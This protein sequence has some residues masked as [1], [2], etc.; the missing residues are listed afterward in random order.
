MFLRIIIDAYKLFDRRWLMIIA[1]GILSVGIADI[2]S[3]VSAAL[4]HLPTVAMMGPDGKPFSFNYSVFID[5]LVFFVANVWLEGFVA[6]IALSEIGGW[7]AKFFEMAYKTT[8][9]YPRVLAANFVA[10]LIMYGSLVLAYAA[11]SLNFIGFLFVIPAFLFAVWFSLVSPVVVVDRTRRIRDVLLRSRYL[12][13]GYFF[14]VLLTMFIGLVPPLVTPDIQSGNLFFWPAMTFIHIA[15]SIIVS[16][17]TV[18]TYLNLRAAKG[19]S[20]SPVIEELTD[21]P[22]EDTAEEPVDSNS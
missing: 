5:L 18:A 13:H 21:A 16:L 2:I 22:P 15:T 19:A 3:L 4:L 20:P 12:V 1:A 17:V 11:L 7:T 6:L 10:Q 8:S 14:T 9:I